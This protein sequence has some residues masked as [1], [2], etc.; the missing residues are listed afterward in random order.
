MTLVANMLNIECQV[1]FAPLCIQENCNLESWTLRNIKH[2]TFV[3]RGP[4]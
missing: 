1:A 2:A 4:Q 3:W